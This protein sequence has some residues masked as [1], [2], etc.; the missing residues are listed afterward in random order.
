MGILGFVNGYFNII[1]AQERGSLHVHKLLWLKH[2]SNANEMLEFL[3]Q[4][5]F[6]EKIAKYVEYN[7]QTHLKGFDDEYVAKTGREKH[8]SY[9]RP[10]N[11]RSN[12]W[13][14]EMKVV[15]QNLARAH[16]VHVCKP[17]TCLQKNR[18]GVLVCK[19]HAPWP[20]VKRTVIHAMGMLDQRQS[21]QFFNGYLPAVLLCLRCNNDMKA[22]LF[23]AETKHIGG[24]LTNYQ[25][26][27]SSK[28]YNMS[29]LLGPALKYH[30]SHQ[31]HMES[32]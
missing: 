30:Q 11:P 13:K 5:G 2:A 26:K 12:Q 29:A 16:Q 27:D 7:I 22:V 15:E 4:P 1:E 8:I 24:Y 17:T 6:C 14:A 28:S 20:L 3:T 19:H 23:G 10:P 25:N 18:Q 21:Y 32:L 9:S 31:P